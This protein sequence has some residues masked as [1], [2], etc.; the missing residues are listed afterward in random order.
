MS[1]LVPR[2]DYAALS[3]CTYLNQAALG[4]IP[5]P[6][7]EA[8][9]AFVDQTAQFGNLYLNDEQEA[10]VLDGVRAAGA[11]LLGTTPDAVAVVGSASEG[12]GQIAAL[13]EPDGGTVVL[14][15]TDFPSVTYP[16]LA[17]AHRRPITIRFVDDHPDRDLTHGLMEAI[18]P[19]TAV[20]AFSSVQYA[21]GTRVD[22]EVVARRAHQVGAR[23]VVDVTQQA[24][25]APVH[26][27]EWQADAMVAS[28]YK[29][30]SAHGGVALLALAP[31]LVDRLPGFV[32]WKGTEDPFDFD[33][34]TLRLA[35]AARRF[36]LS[37]MSYASAVGLETSMAL[38]SSV[39]I[40]RIEEHARRL[41]GRLIASVDESGWRPFRRLRDPAA[42]SHIVSLRHPEH[43]PGPVGARLASDHGIICGRRGGGLRVALH[44]FNSDDDVDLLAAAL[45]G[46]IDTA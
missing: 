31:D 10:A 24:G 16:W 29:W 3:R 37:T 18:D 42:S 34:L 25:A 43:D 9:H 1:S 5:A 20:V 41:A 44:A 33:A 12:L 36:E 45:T 2:D 35:S 26:M 15:S 32:G 21:T 46:G 39:G 13:L 17:A 14:V 19:T 28:G 4:L 30:L 6:T 11:E 7:V 22:S 27:T 23:V 8:M 40:G 38:L